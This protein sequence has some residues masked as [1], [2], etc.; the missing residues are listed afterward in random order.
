MLTSEDALLGGRM[1]IRQPVR[2]LRAGLDAMLLAAAVPI[3]S[4]GTLR[5]LDAGSGSGV[6]GIAVA[7]AAPTLHVTAVDI[8]PELSRLSQENARLNGV[9]G[10][11]RAICA[12]LVAPIRDLARLGIEKDSFDLLAANPPY[13]REG[14]GRPS[15]EPRRERA[16][17]MPADGLEHWARALAALAEPGGVLTM[18][19]RADALDAVLAAL[20][21]RFGGLSILPVHSH[22][23]AAATR[24]LIMGTKGSRAPVSL[25]PGLVLH[26]AA[27][28]YLP[29]VAAMLR[30]ERRLV[31]RPERTNA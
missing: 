27:G 6:V 23:G 7:L 3:R 28:A 4:D 15:P 22:A 2:G 13:H 5:L 8:D 18:I 31:L 12:D 11:F 26:D 19:H 29:E 1:R 14:S 30:G 10:R 20:V 9:D 16:D 25:R 17:V 24:I 21:G